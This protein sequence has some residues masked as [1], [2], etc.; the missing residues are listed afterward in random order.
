MGKTTLSCAHLL[1]FSSVCVCVCVCMCAKYMKDTNE[2]SHTHSLSLITES[3][4]KMA[5]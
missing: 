1:D 2:K 3:M 5:V 4:K